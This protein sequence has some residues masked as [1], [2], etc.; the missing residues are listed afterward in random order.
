V[1]D[2][3]LIRRAYEAWN[4]RNYDSSY[5]VWTVCNEKVTRLAFYMDRDQALRDGAAEQAKVDS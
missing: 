3:D 4:A 1:P 2:H 5:N